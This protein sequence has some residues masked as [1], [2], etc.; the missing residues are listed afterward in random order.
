VRL[1]AT[2]F[3]TDTSIDPIGLAIGLE[4]R[5]DESLWLAEHTHIPIS[6]RSRIEAE[7]SFPTCIGTALHR[8]TTLV[9]HYRD[10]P[11][12]PR[13]RDLSNLRV[14][15]RLNA[16]VGFTRVV[17]VRMFNL[18]E[19]QPAVIA[20]VRMRQLSAP[21]DDARSSRAGVVCP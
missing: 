20:T 4:E 16:A 3:V 8:T 7:K 10:V 12:L 5:G 1:G 11:R 9:S 15:G 19:E 14:Q 6:R 13:A 2:T 21:P 17:A 18:D